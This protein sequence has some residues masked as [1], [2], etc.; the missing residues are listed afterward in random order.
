MLRY[1]HIGREHFTTMQNKWSDN[2][3]NLLIC[4]VFESG[5]NEMS[6]IIKQHFMNVGFLLVHP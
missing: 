5:W 6:I 4:N 1:S 2:S 3:V